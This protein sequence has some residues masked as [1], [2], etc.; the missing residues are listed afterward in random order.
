[1][2]RVNP[3]V[4]QNGGVYQQGIYLASPLTIVLCSQLDIPT[5]A[6]VMK[7]TSRKINEKGFI[8]ESSG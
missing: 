1:M 3:V 7:V 2:N 5:E 6:I 4:I 8:A